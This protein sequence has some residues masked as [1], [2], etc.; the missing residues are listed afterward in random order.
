MNRQESEEKL[1]N[2]QYL[3]RVPPHTHLPRFPLWTLP[4]GL[5]EWEEASGRQRPEES[6]ALVLSA[7]VCLLPGCCVL[8]IHLLEALLSQPLEEKRK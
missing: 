7:F 5:R 8:G 6:E 3:F 4:V 1:R 2:V